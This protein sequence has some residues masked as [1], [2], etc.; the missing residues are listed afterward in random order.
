MDTRAIQS[1]VDKASEEDFEAALEREEEK[2][3]QTVAK[4]DKAFG[5]AFEKAK[6]LKRAF[7]ESVALKQ[8]GD[9]TPYV[10][11]RPLKKQKTFT[12]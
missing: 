3:V 10:L 2:F 6:K 12:C 5:K 8:N 7:E 9:A 4:E 1:R 11:D